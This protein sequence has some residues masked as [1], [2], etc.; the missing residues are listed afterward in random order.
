MG[1]VV[2]VRFVKS[3]EYHEISRAYHVFSRGFN[4]VGVVSADAQLFNLAPNLF[5]NILLL[6]R[7]WLGRSIKNL[8]LLP[9]LSYLSSLSLF[10]FI[11]FSIHCHNF[12]SF[13]FM[14]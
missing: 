14:Q 10:L 13:F 3:R 6:K 1:R 12:L 11:S 8:Y 4:Q 7:D 9:N 5:A 2:L